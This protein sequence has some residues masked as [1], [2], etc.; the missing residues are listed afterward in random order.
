M[1]SSA[2]SDK[3]RHPFSWVI[4]S[5]VWYLRTKV[6]AII[7]GTLALR[8]YTHFKLQILFRIMGTPKRPSQEQRKVALDTPSPAR[9][10]WFREALLRL[11]KPAR[12]PTLVR[13]L[14]PRHGFRHPPEMAGGAHPSARSPDRTRQHPAAC[15]PNFQRRRSPLGRQ[16]PGCRVMVETP[17]DHRCPSATPCCSP[18]GTRGFTGLKSPWRSLPPNEPGTLSQHQYPW[19]TRPRGNRM[20]GAPRLRAPGAP[21]ACDASPGH[22]PLSGPALGMAFRPSYFRLLSASRTARLPGTH[23]SRS[24]IPS[25]RGNAT[26]CHDSPVDHLSW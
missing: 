18:S 14:P 10:P 9:T 25:K 4:T 26:L 5:T 7:L 17:P 12:G 6:L 1:Y 13:L 15:R 20:P 2:G 19:D 23:R 24:T 16:F 22:S 11:R 8:G 3:Y 21:C